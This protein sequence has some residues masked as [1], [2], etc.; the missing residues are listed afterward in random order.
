MFP[1]KKLDMGVL[2]DILRGG[3]DKVVE[4]GASLAGGHSIDDE[5]PKYGLCV[6]GVVSPDRIVTNGGARPGDALVLTKPLGSGVLFN[7]VRS[8]RYS[9]REIERNILPILA[10][11][12]RNAIE[13]ALKFDLRACTDITGFGICGHALEMAKASQVAIL[14]RYRDIPFFIEAHDM[15]KKGETT[16]SNTANRK[17][18]SPYLEIRRSLTKAEEQLLYDPQTSGGLLLAVPPSQVGDLKT[19]LALAN[20]FTASQIGEVLEGDPGLAVV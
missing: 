14:L 12:N 15:Y 20:V 3:D 17:L 2:R 9:F 13:Q 16:G 5:E 4:A 10:T 18:V 11:L 7:A 8:G 1:S 19:A 6:S